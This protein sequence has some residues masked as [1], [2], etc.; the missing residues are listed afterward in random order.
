MEVHACK[1]VTTRMHFIDLD[2]GAAYMLKCDLACLNDVTPFEAG[3]G[4]NVCVLVVK[5]MSANVRL[6]MP[7]RSDR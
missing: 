3:T 6:R 4:L 7:C 2:K 1:D 5:C